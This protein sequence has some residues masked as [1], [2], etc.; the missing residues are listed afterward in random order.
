MAETSESRSVKETHNPDY[1]KM[2]QNPFTGSKP[3]DLDTIIY[4]T[5]ETL[6]IAGILM[7]PFMPGKAAQLLDML[8]VAPDRRSYDDAR[9]GVD[10]DYGVSAV[11][12]GKGISGVL[13]PPLS[14]DR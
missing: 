9:V 12:L 2:P 8:G 11:P 14:S 1:V 6:R 13:F 3:L 5:I 4:N 7:Q 10:G